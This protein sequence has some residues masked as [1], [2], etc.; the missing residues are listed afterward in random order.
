MIPR[1]VVLVTNNE[2]GRPATLHASLDDAKAAVR[3]YLTDPDNDP[4]IT[5]K[6][7]QQMEQD[8]ASMSGD[9]V[10][11]VRGSEAWKEWIYVAPISEESQRDPDLMVIKE[12]D[13]MRPVR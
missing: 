2:G 5:D 7:R 12:I 13:T 9:C 11:S 4:P 10:E 6:E 3:A 8:L 1:Y